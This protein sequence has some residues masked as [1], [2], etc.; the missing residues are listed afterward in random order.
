VD[1][2]DHQREAMVRDQLEA[3]GIT[4]RRVL[5]VMRKVKRHLFVP[6]DELERAYV[7]S[8]L[9]IGENQTISQPYIVA[10]MTELLALQGH[11]KVL[12][13]GTGTGYQSAVLAELAVEVYT[14]ERLRSLAARAERTL[15]ESGYQNIHVLC[16]DGFEG[17]L[18]NAPFNAI[19]VTCAPDEIP[20]TL[21]GQLAEGGRMAIPVGS[22]WQELKLAR[23]K[24][25]NLIVENIT[26][27]RFVPMV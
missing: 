14:V 20:S 27:V 5:D 15:R 10:L 12:E 25:G 9:P 16:S 1:A 19:I 2:F 7:D 11:E 8:P 22:E 26:A 3:R 23:K 6:S 18:A 4:D 24:D 17:W 21:A 13:I